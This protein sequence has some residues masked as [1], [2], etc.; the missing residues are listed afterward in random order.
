MNKK[1]LAEL[2]KYSNPKELYIIT[3]NR[4]L[5]LLLCPFKVLV[6]QDVGD[7]KKDQVVWVDEV[8]VTIELKTVFIISSKAYYY[9]HFEILNE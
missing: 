1:E 5:K 4:L 3:W 8:K 9:F 7:L 6:K 2:L